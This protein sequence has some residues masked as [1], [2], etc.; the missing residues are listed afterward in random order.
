MTISDIKK[1][2]L[3]NFKD[4]RIGKQV[5]KAKHLYYQIGDEFLWMIVFMPRNHR[6]ILVIMI[7]II[8]LIFCNISSNK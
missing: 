6:E 8:L 7:D 2:K 1:I 3:L 5:F 4:I